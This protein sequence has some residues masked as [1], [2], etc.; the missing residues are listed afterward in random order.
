MTARDDNP[1][2]PPPKGPIAKTFQEIL[3]PELI[4]TSTLS[5]DSRRSVASSIKHVRNKFKESVRRTALPKMHNIVSNLRRSVTAI[6]NPRRDAIISSG[7]HRGSYTDLDTR[8]L[9]RSKSASYISLDRS[10][11]LVTSDTATIPGSS[12]GHSG[13][14]YMVESK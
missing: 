7:Q 6:S 1:P 11:T 9:V 14:E 2:T 13:P 8:R 3:P 10:P 4:T 12:I 5:D